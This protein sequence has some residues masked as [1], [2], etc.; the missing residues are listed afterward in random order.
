MP[1]ELAMLE[2]TDSAQKA[3]SQP[4]LTIAIPTFKRAAQLEALLAVLEP[5]L[6]GLPAVEVFVSDNASDDITPDIIATATGRFALVGAR[7]R[8]HRHPENIGAD[9][10]FAFCFSQ[11]QGHFFWMC[12]DDDLIVPDAVAEVLALLQTPTG[13]P[14]ELDLLYATSYGYREDFRS[15]R[16]E[17]PLGRRVHTITDPRTFALVVNI[18]FTFISGIVVNRDRLN[19]VS[20]EAPEAF[21]GTNLVQLS[22]SLPL[23][24]NHRRSAV[25]WTRPVA[26]RV[27]NAH[28]YSLGRVFG[29]QLATVVTRLLP[30]RP[31]LT[32]PILN[33]ALRRWLPSVAVEFRGKAN[34]R[35]S[36][37]DADQELRAAYGNNPRYWLFTYPA[38]K[39]PLPAAKLYTRAT[40]LASK[41][42]YMAQVPGFWRKNT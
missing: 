20:R 3:L 25:L 28:G 10:N 35:L 23:L 9:A 14:A 15:E 41:L 13:Q 2:R 34:D 27:G 19:L 8:T 29:P 24:L 6:A 16:S 7:L 37:D 38:L 5:Q 33:V 22:W 40:A 18:M 17:D 42:M 12:G 26:A 32:G 36:L 4:I 21:I 30:N 11:A 1:P 39:L 31:D